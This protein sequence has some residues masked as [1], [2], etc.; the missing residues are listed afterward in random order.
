MPTPLASLSSRAIIGEY[1][2]RL[3]QGATGWATL[4]SN[5][6]S[7][8]QAGE[9]YKWL[10]MSPAM[11]EWVGER[12]A[13]GL[14][15]AAYTIRNK[16]FE[17]TLEISI[18]DLRRDKTGQIM[19]RIGEQVDRANA[20]WARLLS[21]L[22]VAA[23]SAACY[24]GQSFFDTDHAEG[25]SGTQSNDIQVDI[26]ALPVAATAHGSTTAP[27]PEEL[28]HAILDGTQAVLGYVDDQGEP[29][30]E[31]ARQFLIMVPTS[32]WKAAIAAVGTP[33]MANGATNLIT[34]ADGFGFQIQ[35]NPRLNWTEKFAI[36]RTDGNVKPFIRQ[37]EVPV[38][39][40]A[41]AEG[42]ELEFK[43]RVHQYGLYASGNVGYGYWQQGCLVTLI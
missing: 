24:D 14:R 21:S 2:R 1:F 28:M 34:S 36:F 15:E 13:K 27:A 8:D 33:A 17:S 11:R 3:E 10:G 43:H 9:D 20:H 41:I 16:A 31:N 32:Y 12:Q 26:S 23:E 40:S 5:H 19:V 30:N 37:E 6:F 7:S 18:D 29:M 35:V 38:E 42:S 25:A 39:I 22:I 4:L